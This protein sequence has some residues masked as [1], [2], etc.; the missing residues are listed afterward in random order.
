M[1]KERNTSLLIFK[2]TI[3]DDIGRNNCEGKKGVERRES[4]RMIKSLPCSEE[5]N[6]KWLIQILTE[7]YKFRHCAKNLRALDG[8]TPNTEGRYNASLTQ[9]LSENRGT[10]LW[11]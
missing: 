10:H 9:M 3:S 11:D 4:R 7:K 5:R 1:G 8:F 2:T 6:R